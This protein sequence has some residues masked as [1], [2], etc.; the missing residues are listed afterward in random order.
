MAGLIL[1]LGSVVSTKN[2]WIE[3]GTKSKKSVGSKISANGWVPGPLWGIYHSSWTLCTNFPLG[4]FEKKTKK[5]QGLIII[6]RIDHH[7]LSTTCHVF[8]G[9]NDCINLHGLVIFMGKRCGF[10]HLTRPYGGVPKWGVPRYH[11]PF[12][13]GIFHEINMIKYWKNMKKTYPAIGYPHLGNLHI[14]SNF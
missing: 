14:N 3:P 8:G 4:L 13:A 11:H 12:L 5:K 6:P 1:I 10:N 2:G 7:S 9:A